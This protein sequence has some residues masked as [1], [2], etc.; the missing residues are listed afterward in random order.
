MITEFFTLVSALVQFSFGIGLF[1]FPLETTSILN[2]QISQL[3]Q[4][5][6][7]SLSQVQPENNLVASLLIALSVLFAL[8]INNLTFIR[9]TVPSKLV[10][11]GF[12]G[13]ASYLENISSGWLVVAGFDALLGLIV[14]LLVPSRAKVAAKL[15]KN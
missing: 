1:F 14:W 13:Y 15:K 4:V 6:T 12:L 3:N 8:N 11:A 5:A 2:S 10:F 9:S 7:L